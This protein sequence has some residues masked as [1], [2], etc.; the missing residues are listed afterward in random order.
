MRLVAAFCGFFFAGLAFA[1]P[2]TI[3]VT[4]TDLSASG[5]VDGYRLYRGCNLAG[6]SVGQVIAD[7]ASVGTTYSF[8]G[9][10]D[11]TYVIC[12]IPYNA[13]GDGGFANTVTL[14]FDGVIVPPGDATIILSCEVDAASG[15]IANCVQVNNP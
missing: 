2:A 7:P 8:A 5:T 15:V 12:A 14:S 6:Q 11:N 4:P 9:D 10:T 13:A 3:N 1:V